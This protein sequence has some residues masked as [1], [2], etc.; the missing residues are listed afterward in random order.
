MK[1]LLLVLFAGLL[2][3][4]YIFAQWDDYGYDDY[5]DDYAS[6]EQP[7]T[8]DSGTTNITV[9]NS[10][11]EDQSVQKLTLP[12][13]QPIYLYFY[14]S[15][16]N[17]NP[18]ETAQPVE[19]KVEQK[20]PVEPEPI[21][22]YRYIPAPAPEPPP[23][24]PLPPPPPPQPQVEYR[25]VQPPP[26]Q[27]EYIYIQPPPPQV[28]YV[29]IQ[30]PE[31]VYVPPSPL[32][33]RVIPCLPDPNSSRV[34]RIQVGAYSVQNTAEMMAQRIRSAGLQAGIEYYNSLKRVIVPGVRAE[35]M[36]TIL[37]MLESL[38]FTEV[39]IRE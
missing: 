3:N 35:D 10:G 33:I 1:H 37:Q 21:I 38:G 12:N 34:Y 17:P 18:P 20:P 15:V 39:W 28:E 13:S 11:D 27:V 29:Y 19:T 24:P 9:N 2:L 32:Q 5:D 4:T 36:Y 7:G 31:P 6:D 25:Y 22:E 16:Q 30:P 14:N 26:P 23:P 8:S